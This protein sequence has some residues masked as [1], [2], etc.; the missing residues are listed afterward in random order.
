MKNVHILIAEDDKNTATLI[1]TYLNREGFKTTP[2]QNGKEA[3]VA[4]QKQ[5]FDLVIL[6]IML[7]ELDGW[8]ICR[9]LRKVSDVPILMLTAREEEIDRVLGLSL[10]ADDYVVKPFSP[11]EVV[12]RVKAILR[13]TNKKPERQPC[14]KHGGLELDFAKR[15]VLL[16]GQIVDLTAVEYK[17]LH[18][19]MSMPGKAFSRDDLLN[20]IYNHGEAVI[21]RVV[22]VHIGHLRQKLGDD[23]S[24]P[25][26]IETVRGFGY[27]FVEGD[28]E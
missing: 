8:E 1:E 20:H 2:Y 25:R 11:R 7:P 5:T 23:P 6:D 4:A 16:D 15:K 27:R 19:L 26:F 22:D 3:L 13:R 24:A 18:A 10:G 9:E 28:D 14:F 12:E 21:D 17:I